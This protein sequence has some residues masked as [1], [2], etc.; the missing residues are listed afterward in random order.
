MPHPF[1]SKVGFSSSQ[2]KPVSGSVLFSRA[3]ISFAP[4]IILKLL[5]HTLS[6]AV[7]RALMNEGIAMAARSPIMAVTNI[8]TPIAIRHPAQTGIPDE[9]DCGLM[10]CWPHDEQ[11]LPIA[12]ISLPQPEHLT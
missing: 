5:M 8:I 9:A 12:D 2:L 11:N 7:L 4:E 3:C 1:F 10:I 6:C